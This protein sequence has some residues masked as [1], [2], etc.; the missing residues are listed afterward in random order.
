MEWS[1]SI[2]LWYRFIFLKISRLLLLGT[3]LNRI[4]WASPRSCIGNPS[5][6]PVQ[7]YMWS[8]LWWKGLTHV[9]FDFTLTK[10]AYRKFSLMH[11]IYCYHLLVRDLPWIF[12]RPIPWWFIVLM[13]FRIICFKFMHFSHLYR[14][15]SFYFYNYGL[16]CIESKAL[17]KAKKRH[18]L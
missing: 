13:K 2:A 8:F 17:C 16:Y 1:K 7:Y 14:P 4:L 10:K 15:L 11:N 6:I 12:E 9:W 3:L 5:E 18:R